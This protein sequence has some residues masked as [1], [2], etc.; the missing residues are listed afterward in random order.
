MHFLLNMI[1]TIN[2]TTIVQWRIYILFLQLTTLMLLNNRVSCISNSQNSN[3]KALRG[4]VVDIEVLRPVHKLTQ[5]H[6]KVHRVLPLDKMSRQ[7][8]IIAVEPQI[9]K[10]MKGMFLALTMTQMNRQQ[11]KVRAVI[12]KKMRATLM[13]KLM[14]YQSNLKEFRLEIVSTR[15]L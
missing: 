7:M 14:K 6:M 13:Q 9:I 1:A 10:V 3:H 5:A 2:T 12:I 15:S 8:V 4:Q 11:I